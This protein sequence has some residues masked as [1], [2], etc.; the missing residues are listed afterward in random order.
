[1]HKHLIECVP[2]ISEGR[3]TQ[4][5]ETFRQ[6][7][8]QV[9]GVTLL[10]HHVDPDHHRS[11]LTFVG[12]PTSIV[13]A[14]FEVA[15]LGSQT[16]DIR[17]HVGEH[18]RVGVVDVLPFVPL[19]ESTMEECVSV[20]QQ[21]GK[22]IGSELEIPVFLY[23]YAAS[24]S[25]RTRLEMIRQGGLQ[26]LANRIVH[27]HNWQPDFGPSVP[28]PT[29]G[30]VAVGA[31]QFLIA[32]NIVLRSE[33]VTVAHAIAKSIRTSNGGLPGVKAMGVALKS[34]GLVQVSM[35]VT[36][37]TQTPLSLV[38]QTV[39]QEAAQLGIE[40]EESELVGLIPQAAVS[41]TM[42]QDLKFRSF[43][44]DQILENRMKIKDVFR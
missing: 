8:H 26:E 37:F 20:A 23:E 40:I 18:P 15:R 6:V 27:D 19:G 11:V 22:R 39:H 32:Y 14:A 21:V 28:H 33:D 41:P 36:D 31:R 1:M 7:I 29:A 30:V 24:T 25:H 10:D 5:L 38:F 13:E 12:A 3:D 2:N 17:Q 43:R 34:R 42:A 4:V 9:E 16:L 44:P 35:N